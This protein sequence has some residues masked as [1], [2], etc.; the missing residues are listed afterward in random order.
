MKE[1]ENTIYSGEA[2]AMKKIG[3]IE[4]AFAMRQQKSQLQ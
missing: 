3:D 2:A 1:R 4:T